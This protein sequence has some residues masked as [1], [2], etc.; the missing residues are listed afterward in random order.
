[1]INLIEE[2]QDLYEEGRIELK[3]IGAEYVWMEM[4]TSKDAAREAMDYMKNKYKLDIGYPK[5]NE[6][7]IVIFTVYPSAQEFVEKVK[8]V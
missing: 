4:H 3:P 2:L 7:Q 6:P 5:V 8:D 1:M